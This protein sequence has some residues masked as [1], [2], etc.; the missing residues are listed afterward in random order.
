[1]SVLSLKSDEEIDVSA[2]NK[3][4]ILSSP[5]TTLLFPVVI[6]PDGELDRPAK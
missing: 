1:M 5:R 6:A 3:F 2:Q 4:E